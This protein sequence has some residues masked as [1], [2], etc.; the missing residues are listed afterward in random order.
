[1]FEWATR[2]DLLIVFAYLT[3]TLGLAWFVSSGSRTVEG[4]VLG[5]R[6]MS[7]WV[8]GFSV[9]G[10]FLSSITFLGLPAKTFKGDW[11]A[12][13]FGMALPIAA[14]IATIWFV[15][16]YRK[17]KTRISAFELLE[18]RF[19][20]WA[21]IYADISYL[22]LQLIRIG[23]VLLLVAFALEPMLDAPIP[24]TTVDGKIVQSVAPDSATN[25]PRMIGILI[26]LGVL[27]IVYDTF[28]GF[29]AVVWT[30]V[31]QVFVLTI[32]AI[33]CA[34]VIY[35]DG[36]S[37]LKQIPSEKFS[38]GPMTNVAPETGVW[39]WGTSSVL[40]LL[41]YGVTENLRNYGS[42]QNYVQRILS[43]RTDADAR[44]SLW[45]GALA[46]L[47][48]SVVFCLIGTGLWMH[49]ANGSELI[50]A[51]IE[52]DQAFPYFIRNALPAP[53]AGLIIAGVLAAAMS[54]VDSSL[55]SCSTLILVDILRPLKIIPRSFPEIRAIRMVT[56]LVGVVGT[57][58]AVL[59][60]WIKGQEQSR[61]LMDLWW[62]YAGTAG[63]GLF[64]LFLLAWLMPRI[65]GWVAALAVICG[66]PVLAWGTFARSEDWGQ[67]QCPLHPNLVGIAATCL[68]LVIGLL[69]ITAIKFGWLQPNSR[70][71]E[72]ES[73]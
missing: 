67:W 23:T 4:Y 44:K 27:V 53:I 22:L 70:L 39:N 7:G 9:L 21:R 62:Q 41:L 36:M 25:I 72:L 13:V 57:A 6:R 42:D 37:F 5:D 43:A 2:I 71:N 63:G 8:L 17:N 49:A 16:L 26:G 54:T 15:P 19:G 61:V 68:M 24:D 28:G 14:L 60:L 31:A 58:T 38:L 69:G 12:F 65:P 29:R 32:G 10:T 30:D 66:V 46:Y 35:A 55:N 11:N 50:P 18:E 1:M 20:A 3:A 34:V 51:A 52:A 45:L 59:L 56:V 73:S 64:G 48:L 47:P 40:V 33:W